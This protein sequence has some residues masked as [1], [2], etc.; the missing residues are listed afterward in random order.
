MNTQRNYD[1]VIRLTPYN[2]RYNI[3]RPK[4]ETLTTKNA[5]KWS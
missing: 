4:V 1:S 3:A 2:Y 5:Q